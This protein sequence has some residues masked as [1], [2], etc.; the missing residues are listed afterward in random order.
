VRSFNLLGLAFLV[1]VVACSAGD[2]DKTPDSGAVDS[3]DSGEPAV[4]SGERTVLFEVFTGSTCGPCNGAD[5]QLD[6]V[7][8]LDENDGRWA[9]IKYQVGSD[10]YV[11]AE[12]LNRAVSYLSVDGTYSIPNVVSDGTNVFHP[13]QIN[14]DAGFNQANF[15]SYA[16]VP[17]PLGISVE[18]VISDQTVDFEVVITVIEDIPSDSLRLFTM[19]TENV[20]TANV[21]TNGQTEFHDV[22]KKM[23]PGRAGT[24]L[25]PMVAGDT[26]EMDFSYTFQGEYL[27]DFGYANQVDHDLNHTVEEFEDLEVVVFVQ[28][29]GT[30][31]VHNSAWTKTIE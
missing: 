4:F 21:G 30:R 20:T 18:H 10:P 12:A 11:T 16:D 8:H 25:D 27:E 28:D 9:A 2:A 19:I 13:V 17:S 5:A 24:S 22:M 14:D 6:S 23:V 15:D 1:S 3:G 31:E 29:T 26:L 7:L